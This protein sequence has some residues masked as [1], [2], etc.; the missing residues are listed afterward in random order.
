MKNI[1]IIQILVENANFIIPKD[2]QNHV[3]Q[4][5]LLSISKP[6][7]TVVISMRPTF[8]T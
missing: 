8:L 5:L 1:Q 7:F 6:V 4:G 3:L 2:L